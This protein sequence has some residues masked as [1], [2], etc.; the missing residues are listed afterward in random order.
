MLGVSLSGYFL[1]Y[2]Q[3][4]E[5]ISEGIVPLNSFELKM[6]ESKSCKW[7][8]LVGIGPESTV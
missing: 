1:T 4:N 8:K 2:Q 3:H 6:R 7:L 5:P